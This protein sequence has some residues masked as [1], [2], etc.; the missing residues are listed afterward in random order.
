MPEHVK[1][2]VVIVPGFAVMKQA[3]EPR[4]WQVCSRSPCLSGVGRRRILHYDL[5]MPDA[6]YEIEAKLQPKRICKIVLFYAAYCLFPQ[7]Q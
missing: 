2:S 1:N 5:P 7:A 3:S 4:N 6:P